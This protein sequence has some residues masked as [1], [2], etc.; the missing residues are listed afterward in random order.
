MWTPMRRWMA[1]QSRQMNT[2]YV[3]DAHDGF[4][5]GQSKHTLFSGLL[6]NFFRI[7]FFSTVGT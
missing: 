2:P 6:R 1:L 3:A 5:A 7:A 4:L